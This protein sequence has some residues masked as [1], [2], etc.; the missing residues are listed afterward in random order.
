VADGAVVAA[1]VAGEKPVVVGGPAGVAD[2]VVVRAPA[3]VAPRV[4]AVAAAV[5]VVV[6]AAVRAPAF[7]AAVVVGAAPVHPGVGG[8]V[9]A[10]DREAASS[11]AVATPAA[12]SQTS[13]AAERA[14][15]TTGAP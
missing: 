7:V 10:P 2:G 13:R 9:A 4:G 3:A 11:V 1:R 5:V 12:A 8:E 15:R 6:A 14:R